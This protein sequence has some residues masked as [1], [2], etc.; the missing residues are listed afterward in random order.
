MMPK[1]D[2]IAFFLLICVNNSAFGAVVGVCNADNCLRSMRAT[3]ISGRL[4]TAQSFCATYTAASVTTATVFIPP[5]A[6]NA[7]KDD[8]NRNLSDRLSSA[9]S[10]IRPARTTPVTQATASTSQEPCAE[11]SKSWAA[12]I[13]P[14]G[15]CSKP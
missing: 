5:F 10:C 7:C 4:E 14:G 1:I 2:P 8:R 11:V 9:C 15:E 3:E 13:T 12:Q 6:S